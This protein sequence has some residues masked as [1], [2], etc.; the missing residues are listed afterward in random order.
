MEAKGKTGRITFDGQYITITRD[1]F[2]ARSTVG[3]G[4][5]RLHVAQISGVQWKPAGAVVNGF[6]QFTVPGGNER[7]SRLGSQ[8]NDAAHDE[9]SVVFTKKQQP[10]FE[11]LRQALDVAISAQHAPAAAVAAPSAASMADELA[12]LAALVQSGAITQEEFRQ[13]KARLLGG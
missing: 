13:A 10:A 8:T 12:K 5:K 6:I 4:E 9:N 3:K 2:L 1:T 11:E 7:R